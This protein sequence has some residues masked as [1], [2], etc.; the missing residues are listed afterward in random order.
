MDGF[1]ADV[2]ETDSPSLVGATTPARAG[3]TI[4]GQ[5]IGRKGRLIFQ[6]WSTALVKNGK[7]TKGGMYFIWD[8]D[9]QKG[10][11]LSEALQGLA[12]ISLSARITNV[13][14]DPTALVSESVNGHPCHK[15]ESTVTLSDGGV[16]KVTEWRADDLQRFPVRVHVSS[17]NHEETVDF[18]KVRL[19]LPSPELFLPPSDFARYDSS[20]ALIARPA[21]KKP[22]RLKAPELVP[23][24]LPDPG[25]C[26]RPWDTD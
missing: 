20:T 1:S 8:L 13:V 5:V 22:P 15:T 19:D 10:Y 23:T 25:S 14:A 2:V 26:N 6:P 11:V 18:T 12:Q 24:V 7:I 4:S 3:K 21:S 16:A 9:G 17:A